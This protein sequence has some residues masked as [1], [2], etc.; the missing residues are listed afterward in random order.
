MGGIASRHQHVVGGRSNEITS[1]G[2]L[3]AMSMSA[4]RSTYVARVSHN[5]YSWMRVGDIEDVSDELFCLVVWV[6]DIF[7][8]WGNVRRNI[9]TRLFHREDLEREDST[10]RG[11]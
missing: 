9:I 8:R 7:H 2:R 5:L 11:T 4:D 10:G 6:A 3:G 1:D